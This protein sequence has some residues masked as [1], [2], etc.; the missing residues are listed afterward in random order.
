MFMRQKQNEKA[1]RRLRFEML[2]SRALMA[3]D[4]LCFHNIEIPED[5][6]GSGDV[7][8]LDALVVINRLNSD[9][10]T[11]TST[12]TTMTDVDADAGTSP[13]DALI[14]INYLNSKSTDS[15]TSPTSA[16][17]VES[18]IANIEKLIASGSLASQFTLDEAI[19]VLATLRHG[20]YPE[21]GESLVSGVVV[22][23]DGVICGDSVID[24]DAAVAKITDSLTAASVSEDIITTITTEIGDARTAGTPLTFE[25]VK[26]RLTELGVDVATVF[27]KDH[28]S[29][30]HADRFLTKITEQLTA[31]GVSASIIETITTEIS[32]AKT[33]G[34][35]LTIAQIEA[36]LVELGVDTSTLDLTPPRHRGRSRR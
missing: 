20:G 10:S 22:G 32:D 28:S 34:T 11:D 25:Q 14:V 4:V 21:L 15:T 3:S 12:D 29:D 13:L 5:T 1:R 24:S 31:A 23:S 8:P 6:D 16:V 27:P 17:P 26:T 33:A 9:T 19:D 2:E 7:T 18:R 36:S 35:P 30:S